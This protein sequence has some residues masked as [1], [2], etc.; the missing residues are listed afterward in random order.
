MELCGL[1]RSDHEKKKS[2][3]GTRDGRRW[4]SK[5][6]RS[7]QLISGCVL[8]RL[9]TWAWKRRGTNPPAPFHCSFLHSLLPISLPFAIPPTCR[10]SAS[11]QRRIQAL[12]HKAF[13]I[14]LIARN[15]T[16]RPASASPLFRRD[17]CG[18]YRR[19]CHGKSMACSAPAIST[20]SRPC[21]NQSLLAAVG[22]SP[23][24]FSSLLFP[25]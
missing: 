16:T 25:A 13:G 7:F 11:I 6:F 1:R 24:T 17:W 4:P 23:H 19:F 8:C 10:V 21:S 2:S 5:S 15:Q 22:M 18:R 3:R 20:Q 9:S 12:S 14:Q